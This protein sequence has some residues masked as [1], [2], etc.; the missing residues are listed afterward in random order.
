MTIGDKIRSMTDEELAEWLDKQHN[1]EREDWEPVGCYH[2][3]SYRTHHT[4]KS[5]IGTE[6][7][8]LYECKNCEFENGLLEWLKLET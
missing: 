3:I 8:H 4:D 7:E 5:Y 2:C 6:F 1:D